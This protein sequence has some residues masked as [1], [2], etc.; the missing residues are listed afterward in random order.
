MKCCLGDSSKEHHNIFFTEKRK[1]N[2]LLSS[3]RYQFACT[4]NKDSNQSAHPHSLISLSF[5]PKETFNAW[6]PTERPSKILIDCADVQADL[7]FDERICQRVP[8]AGHRLV[9]I[10]LTKSPLLGHD[11]TDQICSF[12]Q[13]FSQ[14][15][16]PEK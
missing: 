4:Y 11:N 14:E 1:N 9:L 8:F 3:I 13:A 6:L 2:H 10:L 5:P 12:L 16:V 15:C 7:S